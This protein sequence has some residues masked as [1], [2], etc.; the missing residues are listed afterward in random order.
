[1]FYVLFVC[2][3]ITI[4]SLRRLGYSVDHMNSAVSQLQMK[5]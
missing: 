1:M 4:T 2:D 5:G 3:T